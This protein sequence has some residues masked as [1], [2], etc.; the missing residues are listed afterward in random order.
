MD[1]VGM[2]LEVITDLV[3]NRSSTFQAPSRE[4]VQ[5]R[6]YSCSEEPTTYPGPMGLA[7]YHSHQWIFFRQHLANMFHVGLML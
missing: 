3:I 4:W 7:G 5:L 6:C 2:G 1:H